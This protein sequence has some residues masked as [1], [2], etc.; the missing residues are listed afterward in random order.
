MGGYPF[1]R[2]RP[3]DAVHD[4][5]RLPIAT[6]AASGASLLT[7]SLLRTD[8]ASVGSP[9]SVAGPE[10]RARQRLFELPDGVKRV[11]GEVGGVAKVEGFIA[12]EQPT[13]DAWE[14]TLVWRALRDGGQ[15][16]T[17]SV[18]LLDE[19]GRLVAQHDGVPANGT[20]PTTSWL[21]D[22]VVLDTHSMRMLALPPGTYTLIV[23][24]YDAAS[25]QRLPVDDSDHLV[26]GHFTR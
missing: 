20:A 19:A 8:G 21:K 7:I 17:V 1:A 3:G 23:A 2:W 11:A 18:Q 25:G 14:V 13:A 10:I 22:E 15:S 26:L 5:H 4:I 9:L 12:A 24:L 6:Q 16:Y